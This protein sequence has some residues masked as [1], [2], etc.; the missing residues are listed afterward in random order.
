MKETQPPTAQEVWNEELGLPVYAD[1]DPSR[2]FPIETKVIDYI[3][4][5]EFKKI[6]GIPELS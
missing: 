5:K 1:S 2:V 4:Q 6:G 3:T